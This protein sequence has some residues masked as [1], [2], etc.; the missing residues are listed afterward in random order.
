M[1]SKRKGLLGRL[2]LFRELQAIRDSLGR[3]EETA[4]GAR[5]LLQ[6]QYVDDLLLHNP[7]YQ[8]PRRL[9]GHEHQ[10][11][12]QNGEDGVIAEIFRRI[13]TTGREF[14]EIGV[15]D[16]M[17][18][19]TTYLLLQ[20]WKG[21]WIEA[22]ASQIE[23]IRKTFAP[24]LAGGQLKIEQV[25]VKAENIADVLR[26]AN[27]TLTPDLLSIDVDRNTWFIWQ[28]LAHVQARVVVIEYNALYPPAHS[29]KVSYAEDKTWNGTAHFGAS[30]KAYEELGQKLGYSLVG[31]E[32][33]GANAFFVRSDLVGNHFCEPFTAENHYE[34]PRYWLGRRE[35]HP[36]CVA[37]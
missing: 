18:N 26:Q 30:L 12:S 5:A 1:S 37:D 13:G 33:F 10:V 27:A 2:P 3:A 29:W 24:Q 14:V 34:P 35:G 31:C 22:N 11:Y 25:F 17:E 15:G 19:N 20:G 9:Q 7:R 21:C 16:G 6:R 36:R 32:L 23:H 28:A 8:D 4:A